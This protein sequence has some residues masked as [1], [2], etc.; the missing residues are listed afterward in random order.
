MAGSEKERPGGVLSLKGGFRTHARK[1]EKE[2]RDG[3]APSPRAA[4]G[5]DKG[6]R[7]CSWGQDKE[8]EKSSGA[9]GNN[10]LGRKPSSKREGQGWDGVG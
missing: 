6:M 2:G 9:R 3:N 5:R 1:A 10:Y 4:E 7:R 8:E